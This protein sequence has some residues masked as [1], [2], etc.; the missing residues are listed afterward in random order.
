MSDPRYPIGEYVPQAFS[1]E[2]KEQWLTDIRFLPQ[3]L[4]N[5]VSN[6]DEHQLQTAYRIGGWSVHQ[7]VHHIADSHM[8]AYLRFKSGYAENS[9]TIKPYDQNVWVSFSDVKNLPINVSITLL[10]ALHQRWHEFLRH[11]SSADWQRTLYHPEY[12]KQF[13]L[14]ELFGMYAWHG[15]HHVAHITSLRQQKSW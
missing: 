12:Q 10:H 1:E 9:P 7:L 13:T 11:F 5:A 2:L 15:R 8:N 6:L 4:E 14:W 3:I